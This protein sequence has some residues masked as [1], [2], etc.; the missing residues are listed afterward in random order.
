MHSYK[1]TVVKIEITA[2]FGFWKL[3]CFFELDFFV[4]VL[5]GFFLLLFAVIFLGVCFTSVSA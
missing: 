1:H 4:C 3:D 5:V 2:R